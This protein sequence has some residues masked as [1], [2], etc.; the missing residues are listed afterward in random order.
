MAMTVYV[1]LRTGYAVATPFESRREWDIR[2][3]V[4][5]AES[6]LYSGVID[7]GGRYWSAATSCRDDDNGKNEGRR[8]RRI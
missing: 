8:L 6:G 4:K 5:G 2:Y 3:A 7:G 1:T